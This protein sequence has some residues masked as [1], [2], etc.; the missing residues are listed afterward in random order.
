[1]RYIYLVFLVLCFNISC[2][3]DFKYECYKDYLNEVKSHEEY[4]SV[5][6]TLRDSISFW[7]STKPIFA[8]RFDGYFW[9]ISENLF[10]NEGFNKCIL[11]IVQIDKDTSA[12]FD[13][14]QYLVGLRKNNKWEFYLDSFPANLYNRITDNNSYP[15]SDSIL[16]KDAS[17]RLIA[18]GFISNVKC[19]VNY[20]YF[21]NSTWFDE[22]RLKENK[23]IFK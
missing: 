12:K 15:F 14:V 17:M 11:L 23:W 1:M 7:E 9:S 8:E 13:K 3:I 22:W 4:L 16:V 21:E 2:S 20:D 5:I 10:C 18:D 19:K 6:Q